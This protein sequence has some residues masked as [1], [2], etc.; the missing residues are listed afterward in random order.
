MKMTTL[1]KLLKFLAVAIGTVLL[2]V[3]IFIGV[4]IGLIS[5]ARDKHCRNHARQW[6][7]KTATDIHCKVTKSF[8]SYEVRFG[9]RTSEADFVRF[10]QEHSHVVATNSFTMLDYRDSEQE[11]SSFNEWR[12]EQMETDDER[13]RKLVFD[14]APVPKRFLSITK[15]HAFDGGAVG[16]SSR[17]IVVFDQDAGVLTGYIYVNCL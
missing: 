17:E 4:S 10:A 6:M 2:A 8:G 9:C 13:Q 16:G 7:P 11:D 5:S 3:A 14:G 1:K 12:R 15:S